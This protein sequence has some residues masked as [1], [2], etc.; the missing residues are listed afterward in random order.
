MND[1]NCSPMNFEETA[2]EEWMVVIR[3]RLDAECFCLCT[4]KN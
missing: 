2:I 1:T 3:L 4:L